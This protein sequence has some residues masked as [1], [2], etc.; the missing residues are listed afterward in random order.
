MPE[1]ADLTAELLGR[2]QRVEQAV[3]KRPQPGECER[4]RT[5]RVHRAIRQEGLFA[6]MLPKALGGMEV[7]LTLAMSVW[8]AT[9]KIDSSAGWNLSQA[10]G[11]MMMLS[12]MGASGIERIMA[13]DPLPVFA[14]AAFP[15]GKAIKVD[16]GYRVTAR[17]PFASGCRQADWLFLPGVV[18][19]EDGPVMDPVAQRPEVCMAF[20][21]REEVEIID[22]WHV[23]GMRGTESSDIQVSDAFVP[24]DLAVKL[25]GGGADG[26]HPAFTGPLYR[27]GAWPV[28]NGEAVAALGIAAAAI[29]DFLELAGTKVPATTQVK[30]CERELAQAAVAKARMLL[31]SARHYLH[32]TSAEGYAAAAAGQPLSTDMKISLQ[33]ANCHVVQACAQA[34]DLVFEAAGTSAIRQ[35]QPLERHFRDVHV[36]TQHMTKNSQRLVSAGRMMFGM[37]P[38]AGHLF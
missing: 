11:A 26:P 12:N 20:F 31:E 17:V 28:I 35:E 9:S 27:M 25:G 8:E 36:I 23:L 3:G 21:R 13:V 2:V 32:A 29:E 30:L 5:A 33:L 22:T 16:G 34:V 4:E 1:S 14:G 19:T 37:T 6:L 10:G 18:C 7:P 38:D 15:P 24:D